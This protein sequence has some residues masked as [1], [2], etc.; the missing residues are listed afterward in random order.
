MADTCSTRLAR[1]SRFLV[2]RESSP[3]FRR[4]SPA[5][6]GLFSAS[7]YVQETLLTDYVW[8]GGAGDD[9]VPGVDETFVI[10]VT[11]DDLAANGL[12]EEDQ[13]RTC[14]ERSVQTLAARKDDIAGLAVASEERIEAYLLYIKD[15]EIL[16]LRTLVEDRGTRLKQLLY[17]LRAA[18]MTGLPDPE[19]P[20]GGD[21]EGIPGDARLPGRRRAST[22]RRKGTVRLD[23]DEDQGGYT[24]ESQILAARLSDSVRKI[25]ELVST[26]EVRCARDP[27]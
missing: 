5:A 8:P 4:R 3:K 24:V 17:R 7:G 21:L 16:S 12:L 26:A 27:R 10:P 11:V 22:L 18:G 9:E 19:G 15:G 13:P 14:W 2:R 1:S 6:S 23:L 25:L 20:S